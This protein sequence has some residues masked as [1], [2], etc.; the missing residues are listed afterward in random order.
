MYELRLLGGATVTTEDGEGAG[1]SSRRHPLA[2]LAL[3]ATA[4][5]RT[6]SRG[7]LVGLLWPEVPEETARNRLTSCVYD[8]RS[9]LGAGTLRT[10]GEELRYDPAALPADV[11]RFERAIAAGDHRRAVDLYGGP[12]LD[13]FRLGGSADFEQRVDR[14]RD[15][16]RR[17]YLGALESLAREA[18][19]SGQT[20]PA[21]AW[22]RTRS[23]EEPHDS[24]VVG[25]L[26][27]ALVAAGNRAEALRVAESHARLLEEEFGT[28]PGPDLRSLV[29]RLRATPS[30]SGTAAGGAPVGGAGDSLPVRSI[31]VLPFESLGPSEE[32]AAFAAGLHEDLL[33]ELSR[34]AGL[35]VISRTSV[36]RYRGTHRPVPEIAR[37]LGVGTIVEGAVRSVGDRVRLNVQLIDARTDAHRWVER[38]DRPLTTANLFDIQAELAVRIA[39]T[40]RAELTPAERDRVGQAPPHDLEAFRLYAQGRGLLDQRTQSSVVRSIDYFRG[41]IDREPGYALAW[42]GLADAVSVLEFYDYDVPP[43]APEPLETARRAVE[44]GPELGQARASLGII[45]SIRQQGP[46]ALR[47]LNRAIELAPSYAEAHAWLAWLHL[48]RGTPEEAVEPARRAVQLDPLAPAYRAYLG[49]VLLAK[50]EP[51][52]ALEATMR[53]REI[54]PEYGLPHYVEGLVL[55]HLGRLDEARAALERAH[56]RVPPTGTPC[57]PE[58]I[59]ALAVVEIAAGHGDAAE[60]LVA[61]LEEY[62]HPFSVGL[63]YAALG[64]TER[65]FRWFARVD[66]W[67]SFSTEIFRYFFTAVLGP[68]REDPRFLRI[69]R[70]LDRRWANDE[71][72]G[73]PSPAGGRD[74]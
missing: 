71:P 38:F 24:R 43:G 14:E 40:L 53:A 30:G 25:E 63:G 23:A 50:G 65:A 62:D 36:Q 7:K 54:Q 4:P 46:A 60:R 17:M 19:K 26:M 1:I 20:G 57:H 27:R 39:E 6:L 29:E 51:E 74:A 12:F 34:I 70:E 35:T 66:D 21:V 72:T 33:T 11:D 18:A 44:L 59:A 56:R 55:H 31:A 28:Q 32:G 45:H 13:G 67:S 10:R 3:L 5:G 41:A 52:R 61:R 73:R 48:L 47:E 22:W 49:E 58:V 16:L 68:L 42:A 15:R 37:E 64:Q 2:L 69:L 8:V 9:S